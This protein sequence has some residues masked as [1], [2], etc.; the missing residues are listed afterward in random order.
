MRKLLCIIYLLATTTSIAQDI[1]KIYEKANAAV[2]S[3]L[4]LQSEL[5]GVGEQKSMV[6]LQ[7]MGSGFVISEA[8]DIMTASHVVQTAERIIVTFSDGDEV[9]AEVVSSYPIVDVA[10]IKLTEEKSTPLPV[11]KM[12]DSDEVRIGEQIFVIG[13]PFGLGHS[14]SVG[15]VSGKYGRRHLA[16]GFVSTEFIQ[17]D[18]AI[19]KGSSGSPVF[20][21]KGEVIGIASFIL[22][23][24]EGFQ[25]LSFA[26]TINIAQ[27]LLNQD[28]A[29]CT[30]ME[31]Y[32]IS[33]PMAEILN[34]PQSG[35]ILVQKV[36]SQSPAAAI[37]LNSGFYKVNID[38]ENIMLGGDILWSMAD[39]PLIDEENVFKAWHFVQ[40]LEKDDAVQLKVLRKGKLLDLN[41]VVP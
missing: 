30:G 7:G 2:V 34:L 18:A 10:L 24:S 37:G 17:T 6:A 14:L 12:A 32:L 38:G 3:I 8:G 5:L 26:A 20:N 27:K 1:S 22:S 33:G 4:T 23:H 9:P 39:I 31:S 35:G 13:A 19:N 16:G 41:I 29:I 21:M 15:H 36:A 40:G 25:G 28:R 11:A